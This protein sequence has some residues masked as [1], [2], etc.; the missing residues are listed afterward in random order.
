MNPSNS[1]QRNS[2]G[3]KTPSMVTQR[4]ERP[5][6]NSG[7]SWP[8]WDL[9]YGLAERWIGVGEQSQRAQD[10]TRGALVVAYRD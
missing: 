7:Q 10:T 8:E 2:Q 4:G 9:S 6:V 1:A 5:Q 3:R